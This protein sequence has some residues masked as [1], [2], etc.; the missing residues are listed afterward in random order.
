MEFLSADSAGRAQGPHSGESRELQVLP[1]ETP[2]A[3]RA[4]PLFSAG[5]GARAG[6]TRLIPER[7]S[8]AAGEAGSAGRPRSG[9]CS[10][11][12]APPR[13]PLCFVS[14]GPRRC[15]SHFRSWRLEGAGWGGAGS[16]AGSG[17]R[18]GGRAAPGREAACPGPR[19]APSRPVPSR[20]PLPRRPLVPHPAWR[21][22]VS[23][24][25]TGSRLPG[26]P[27]KKQN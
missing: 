6:A 27:R 2:H 16:C 14:A 11:R 5:S 13:P 19:R 1:G 7:V 25:G 23:A 26:F 22:A 4:P 10:P 24:I 12:A 18:G 21:P 8:A 3:E 17:G 15:D 20:A 9:A